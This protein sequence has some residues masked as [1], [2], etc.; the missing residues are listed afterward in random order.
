[1]PAALMALTEFAISSI[2]DVSGVS[3]ELMG[4]REANQPGVLEYQRRQSSMTTLAGY[5]DSLRYYRK[6]QGDTILHFLRKHIAPTGR[7]VRM[8]KE[9]QE[10]YVPLAMDDDARKYDVIVDDAPSAPN[11]KEKAWSVI[12]AMMP[13]LQQAGLSLEDWAD[14]LEYSPLPSS[15]VDKVRE[16]AEEAKQ[17]PNPQQQMQEQLAQLQMQKEQSELVENNAAAELDKAKT[18]QVLVETAL[19]P[20]VAAQDAA[21]NSVR[22]NI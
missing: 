14:V 4:M 21:E 2:R 12:E 6:R 16:K 1:M 19:A 3:M 17:K 8:L 20:Q 9:G 11:E 10:Q 22:V 15:F 18:Q 5:F 13:M 7:L